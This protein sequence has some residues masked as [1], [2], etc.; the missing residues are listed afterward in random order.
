[1]PG[2][3]CPTDPCGSGRGEAVD[4]LWECG[5]PGGSPDTVVG[6]LD[7]PGHFHR[8]STA[9][10]PPGNRLLPG[11]QATSGSPLPH[12]HILFFYCYLL[13]LKR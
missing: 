6:T 12:F 4:A 1:M 3:P 5:Q 8:V 2:P 9:P 13:Y 10:G 11:P 7:I